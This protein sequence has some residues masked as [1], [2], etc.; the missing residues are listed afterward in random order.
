MS[1]TDAWRA[2]RDAIRRDVRRTELAAAHGV[3]VRVG[4]LMALGMLGRLDVGLDD[5]IAYRY[6]DQAAADAWQA[7]TLA[8][9]GV[10]ALGTHPSNDGGVIGVY[11]IRL[12]SLREAENHGA[13]Q[14]KA[15]SGAQKGQ[16]GSRN[17]TND[18][19][20]GTG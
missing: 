18:Q 3:P 20:P 1:T 8:H 15:G 2:Q 6:R 16:A 17:R 4:A 13:R 12:G 7:S 5:V 19:G 11:D 14:G 10:P 9:N